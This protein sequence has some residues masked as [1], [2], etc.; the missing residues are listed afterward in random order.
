MPLIEQNREDY[1]RT[2]YRLNEKDRNSVR[3][4]DIARYLNI[5]KASVSEMLK[6]LKDQKHIAMEPYSSIALTKKGLMLAKKLTYKHQVTEAFLKEILKVDKG[7]VHAEAHKFEHVVS[8]EIANKMAGLLKKTKS[9]PR[10]SKIP[11]L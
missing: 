3:S 1:F 8:D 9:C 10:G 11:E 4:V 2:I 5:S 7:K 6:K